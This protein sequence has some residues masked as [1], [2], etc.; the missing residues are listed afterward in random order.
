M[1][2]RK[3]FLGIIIV[4]YLCQLLILIELVFHR[5]LFYKYSIDIRYSIDKFV[6]IGILCNLIYLLWLFFNLFSK[7]KLLTKKH[8][9][10]GFLAVFVNFLIGYMLLGIIPE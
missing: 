7:N 9:Y 4:S 6:G 10:I 8:M 2:T 1:K 5:I 3:I